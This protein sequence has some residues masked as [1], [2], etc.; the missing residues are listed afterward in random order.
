MISKESVQVDSWVEPGAQSETGDPSM[1]VI[2]PLVAHK[3]V[4]MRGHT[5]VSSERGVS[6]PLKDQSS[7]A[8]LRRKGLTSHLRSGWKEG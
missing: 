5:G 4:A 3:A 7:E 8:G 2:S 1:E 6:W